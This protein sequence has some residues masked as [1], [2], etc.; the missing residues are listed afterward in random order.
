MLNGVDHVIHVPARPRQL[1]SIE[2]DVLFL[3]FSHLPFLLSSSTLFH[4]QSDIKEHLWGPPSG[5]TIPSGSPFHV[6]PRHVVQLLK[7]RT[8]LMKLR[9]E[10]RG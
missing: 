6:F 2:V 4:Y 1:L 10:L 8:A 7:T 9:A 3:P 5:I